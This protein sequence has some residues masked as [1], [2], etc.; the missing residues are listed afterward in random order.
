MQGAGCRVYGWEGLRRSSGSR[1][2]GEGEGFG[3]QRR[4]R[5]VVLHLKTPGTIIAKPLKSIVIEYQY[6]DPVLAF[7]KTP[8]GVPGPWSSTCVKLLTVKSLTVKPLTVAPL[9][10]KSLTVKRLTVKPLTAK[11]L[12]VKTRVMA[13]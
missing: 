4:Q 3:D 13:S 1:G 6:Y 11:P 10:A 2:P 8:P 7:T 5:P 9:T 12:T